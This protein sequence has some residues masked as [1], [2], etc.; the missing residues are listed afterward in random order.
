MSKSAK[1]LFVFF[2]VVAAASAGVL[3]YAREQNRESARMVAENDAAKKYERDLMR[4]TSIESAE[5]FYSERVKRA[6]IERDENRASGNRIAADQLYES[7]VA[8]LARERDEAIEKAKERY[9]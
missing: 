7:T 9:P 8:R 5:R 2:V 6:G 4:K 3:F 1:V